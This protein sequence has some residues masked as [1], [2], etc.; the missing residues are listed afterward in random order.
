MFMEEQAVWPIFGHVLNVLQHETPIN[1]YTSASLL[2]Q[3]LNKRL[4]I[5]IFY[6]YKKILFRL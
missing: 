4:T 2:E 6:G 5:C 3:Y 1:V